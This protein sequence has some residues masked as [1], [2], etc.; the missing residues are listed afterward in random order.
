MKDTLS[1]RQFLGTTSALTLGGLGIAELF[2][3]SQDLLLVISR[4][5]W[6][7][8]GAEVTRASDRDALPCEWIEQDASD[9]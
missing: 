1:R 7:D 4:T 5:V 9:A 3:Q 6:L 8:S 2:A